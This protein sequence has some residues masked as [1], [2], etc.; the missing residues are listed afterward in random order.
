[1]YCALENRTVHR[2]LREPWTTVRINRRGI[3]RRQRNWPTT[4]NKNIHFAMIRTACVSRSTGQTIETAYAIGDWTDGGLP[5]MVMLSRYSDRG[6]VRCSD[7][8][9]I[10]KTLWPVTNILLQH[11]H[12]AEMYHLLIWWKAL[13]PLTLPSVVA[14][15]TPQRLI[16]FFFS[17]FFCTLFVKP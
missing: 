16:F 13:P 7:N 8:N 6:C 2:H 14:I 3:L 10:Y 4:R 1:M 12:A 11:M 17:F 15:K 5:W 9:I